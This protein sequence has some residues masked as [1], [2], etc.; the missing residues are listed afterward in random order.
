[1][2]TRDVAPAARV[3]FQTRLLWA[4]LGGGLPAVLFA[5]VL[6][7]QTQ[8]PRSLRVAAMALIV[9]SWL[10][11]AFLAR[12]R[13]VFPLQTLANLLE[14]LREGDYT[15]RGRHASRGDALG[16]VVHEV[17]ALGATLRSQRLTALEAHALLEKVIGAL[18][19]AV[20]AFDR[21]DRVRLA[22]RAAAQLL[23]WPAE[24]LPGIAAAELGLAAFLEHEGTRTVSHTFPARSGRWEIATRRF[25]ESG[26]S[27]RLLVVTDLSRALREEERRAWQRLIRVVGHEINNSLTPIKSLAGTLGEVIAS[28]ADAADPHA[29]REV[30]AGLQVIADRAD[31]LGRFVA[32]Y[33]QLARMPT[34]ARRPIDLARLLARI[35]TLEFARPVSVSASEPLRIE[36]DPTQLEQLLINLVKN[37]A[38]AAEATAGAVHI[39]ARCTADGVIIDVIDDGEGV[40]NPDNLFVPFFTTKPGG[41]GIGLVLSRQIAEAHDGTV[42]LANRKDAR[43]CIAT[44]T[45]PRGVSSHA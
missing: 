7:A 4:T 28:D 31:A 43:G 9:V 10:A 21:Q 29:R 11:G 26:L 13:V 36:A 12:R 35:A 16:E 20:L 5:L 3:R 42:E 33:S 8:W 18:D 37:A 34:P 22:N 30:S 45:L 2:R 25:R 44:V 6:L 19:V 14:A 39:A 38:E 40:A 1:M 24:R 15:L 41:T 17:N 32:T 27:H 23:V